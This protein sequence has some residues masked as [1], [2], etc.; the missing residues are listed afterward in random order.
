[1][2]KTVLGRHSKNSLFIEREG[3]YSL[4][5][6]QNSK[7]NPPGNLLEERKVPKSAN[8]MAVF[9]ENRGADFM[10]RTMPLNFVS[11]SL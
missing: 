6:Y 11:D 9:S 1:M 7:K 4:P 8:L 3:K 2:M 10:L 5:C